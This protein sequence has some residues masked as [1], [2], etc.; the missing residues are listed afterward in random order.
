MNKNIYPNSYRL[1]LA[2]CSLFFFMGA[3][4]QAPTHTPRFSPVI[5]YNINGFWEYLPRNYDTDVSTTYSLLIYIHGAGDQGDNP[6]IGQLNRVL[7]GGPARLINSGG[8][9]DSFFVMNRWHKF[10]V[11][12]PQIKNGISGNTSTILPSTIE[13][14]IQYAKSTYRVDPARIYLC[15]LSMGGGATWDYAGSS[16]TAARQLAAIAVACGAGDLSTAEANVIA[17]ADLPVVATHNEPDVVISVDRTRNNISQILSYSPTISP[18]PRAVYWSDGGHNVWTRTFEDILPGTTPGGNLRDT[19]GRNVYEWMLQFA[20]S[21]AAPLPVTWQ[22]FVVRAQQG[23]AWLQWIVSAQANVK[24]Y[25]IERSRNGSDWTAISTLQAQTGTG[26]LEYQFTDAAPAG[27]SF[28]RIRQV[29][30]DGRFTYS[31]IKKF[32]TEALGKLLVYPNPFVQDIRIDAELLQEEVVINLSDGY[33]KQVFSR[34]YG[35]TGS[36][37]ILKDLGRL[38]AGTYYLVIRDLQGNRLYNAPIVKN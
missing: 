14:V 34:K 10:I 37:I 12:S 27:T 28:Y 9:P 29:D 15:G 26:R 19:L 22:S 33:G 4:A 5:D 16:L 32:S 8:F 36:E 17:E 3:Q 35:N 38:P 20:R 21:A 31:A 2:A 11:L 25:I 6:N 18:L 13:A 1:L 7:R 24:E 23:K 30:I